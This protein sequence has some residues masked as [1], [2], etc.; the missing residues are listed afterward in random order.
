MLTTGDLWPS[1]RIVE[2][3]AGVESIRR[4][5][6]IKKEERRKTLEEKV[7][8]Y[9]GLTRNDICNC[10]SGKKYKKCCLQSIREYKLE[11]GI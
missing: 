2:S 7:D 4:E 10:G 5:K 1:E 9:K 3:D 6:R 11:L 8:M